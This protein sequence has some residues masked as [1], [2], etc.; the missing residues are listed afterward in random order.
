MNNI[1]DPC[2]SQSGYKRIIACFIE[3]LMFDHN[4]CSATVRGYVEAINTLFWLCNLDTPA[5]LLDCSNMCTKIILAREREENIARQQ[6]PIMRKMFSTLLE[7]AKKLPVDLLVTVVADWFTFIRITGL[8]CAEY[9]QKTQSEV[10]KYEYPLG[11]CV[12]KAFTSNDWKFYN[13]RGRVINI[14]TSKSK[15]QEFPTKLKIT[16]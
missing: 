2:G 13:S 10:N 1:P 5:D 7:L 9:A 14:H 6:S 8:R 3:Q 16:F 15:L 11:K 4:S 12:V